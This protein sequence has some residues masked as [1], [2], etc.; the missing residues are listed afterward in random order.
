MFFINDTLEKRQE[1]IRSFAER[2]EFVVAVLLA[3]T[4]FEWTVRRAIIALGSSPT[5]A[6]KD[7]GGALYR[8]H[9]LS[10]YKEAWRIEVK[11]KHHVNLADLVPTWQFFSESAYKLRHTLVHGTHGS[12]S[13]KYAKPRIE[14]IL[15]ASKAIIEFA[16]AKNVDLYSR[17][18][19]RQRPK[20]KHQYLPH[21]A[22]E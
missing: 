7:Y 4:D 13:E 10:D 1:Y 22:G 14:A 21:L 6:I 16:S 8:R 12:V 17:I 11:P 20:V 15:N 3:A 18:K 9:G 2:G 5:A 19:V